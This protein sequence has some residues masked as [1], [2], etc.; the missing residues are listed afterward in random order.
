MGAVLVHRRWFDDASRNTL[1]LMTENP[2]YGLC[3]C[4]I[5]PHRCL[6]TSSE[7]HA[8]G[9]REVRIFKGFGGMS[10][11]A[12]SVTVHGHFGCIGQHT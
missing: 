8:A 1:E 9:E 10:F 4:R 5:H 3:D 6:R 11:T 7:I 2:E 12:L